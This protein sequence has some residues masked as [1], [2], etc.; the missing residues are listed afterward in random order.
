[1]TTSSNEHAYLSQKN[2]ELLA[3][4]QTWGI[5]ATFEFPGFIAVSLD[6]AVE[7]SLTMKGDDDRFL[8]IDATSGPVEEGWVINID[9]SE[10]LADHTVDHKFLSFD[11]PVSDVACYISDLMHQETG[12]KF[13]ESRWHAQAI[14]NRH[15][16]YESLVAKGFHTVDLAGGCCAWFGRVGEYLVLINDCDAYADFACAL[17]EEGDR[18][19][20]GVYATHSPLRDNESEDAG[21]M[22][23]K[24][25]D[26]MHDG[27]FE[28]EYTFEHLW[29]DE[30]VGKVVECLNSMENESK[31][32]INGI[33]DNISQRAR[34][35]I[36][37]AIDDV[38]AGAYCLSALTTEEAIRESIQNELYEEEYDML[39]AESRGD[40]FPRSRFDLLK[41]EVERHT[42]GEFLPV[43]QE[44]KAPKV[45]E[46]KT[47]YVDHSQPITSLEEGKAYLDRCIEAGLIWHLEDDPSEII[48]GKEGKPLFTEEEIPLVRARCDELY[49]LPS[50]GEH[51][52]PIGYLWQGYE[53]SIEETVEETKTPAKIQPCE[54]AYWEGE[55]ME[56]DPSK[57]TPQAIYDAASGRLC[58]VECGRDLHLAC[59]EFA[60]EGET[61]A[62]PVVEEAKPVDQETAR[63]SAIDRATHAAI[64]AGCAI[65]QDALG[66]TDGGFASCHFTGENEDEVRE[67]FLRYFDAQKRWMDADEE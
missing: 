6:Q 30:I 39:A 1:M 22:E 10:G 31:V 51:D 3:A 61:E 25:H 43:K 20:A 26:V 32:E 36:Y 52:C 9:S 28:F 49:A 19:S 24:I 62:A 12:Y 40:D 58:C 37:K 17:T 55:D 65:I 29:T 7:G 4:L 33:E 23:E 63:L 64:N 44:R 18:V 50:W 54:C 35:L 16:S 66:E 42:S 53:E 60:P 46:A 14:M 41:R 38:R 45:E 21:E 67:V 5:H 15:A 48:N 2:T 34:A 56:E 57:A 11:L 8:T 47:S 27:E 59:G 13:V